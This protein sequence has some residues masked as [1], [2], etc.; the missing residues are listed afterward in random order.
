MLPAEGSNRHF[1]DFLSVFLFHSNMFTSTRQLSFGEVSHEVMLASQCGNYYRFSLELFSN[2]HKD[3]FLERSQ[4]VCLFVLR[5]QR[6]NI[7]RNKK[8]LITHHVSTESSC[9]TWLLSGT[10]RPFP[11]HQL[12]IIVSVIIMFPEDFHSCIFP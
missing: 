11:L 2:V 12:S 7:V 8:M 5:G 4:Y 3:P 1:S 10:R 9:K 6:Q